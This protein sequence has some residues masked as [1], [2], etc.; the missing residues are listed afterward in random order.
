M[1]D[2]HFS[3][4]LQLEVVL[5]LTNINQK[6]IYEGDIHLEKIFLNDQNR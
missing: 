6:T 2:S 5:I 3:S 4:L 1:P